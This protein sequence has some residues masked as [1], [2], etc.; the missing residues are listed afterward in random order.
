M[1]YLQLKLAYLHIRVW[2]QN[3]KK[4][5]TIIILTALLFISGCA[6]ELTIGG[7]Q[8]DFGQFGKVPTVGASLTWY[9]NKPTEQDI[10]GKQE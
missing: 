9:L 5:L 6:D 10:K 8:S 4:T 1:R 2:L 3:M 7:S